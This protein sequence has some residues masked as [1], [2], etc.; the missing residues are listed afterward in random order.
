MEK[1]TVSFLW[2][3]LI[4]SLLTAV[5]MNVTAADSVAIDWSDPEVRRQAVIETAFAYYLK[6]DCIQ[7]DSVALVAGK[8]GLRITRKTIEKP[9]EY[10]TPDCIYHTVCSAFPYETYL[11]AIGYKIGGS[12]ARSITV[13]LALVPQEGV[14]VFSYDRR[15]DPGLKKQKSELERMRSLLEPGDVIVYVQIWKDKKTGRKREGGHA[16]IYLGDI[17][18]DGVAKIMHSAGN[19]YDFGRGVDRLESKG[20]IRF[21]DFDV[22]LFRNGK[23][24]NRTKIVVLRPLMLSAA[25]WP[26][27]VSAKAR[28]LH[29]RL[30]I[31]R[32]VGCGPYGSVVSG[33]VLEYSINLKNYSKRP[34][35]VAVHENLPN[36]TEFLPD[37][38][39]GGV[40]FKA[41]SEG[42]GASFAWD[43]RLEPGELRT[44]RWCVRV[45]APAGS[46]IVSAGGNVAGIISNTL[47][48]E[49]VPQ[50]MS[51]AAAHWWAAKNIHNINA[52]PDCRLEGWAGGRDTIEPP[53]GVRVTVPGSAQLMEGDVV[54]VCPEIAKPKDFNIWVKGRSGFEA[55]SKNGVRPVLEEEVTAILTN[56]FFA[57]L[58]P[59]R[60]ADS[61]KEWKEMRRRILDEAME[62]YR[63]GK[64]YASSFAYV[65]ETYRAA[66]GLSLCSGLSDCLVS[67]I[68]VSPPKGSVVF[69]WEKGVDKEGGRFRSEVD[70]MRATIE[71]GDVIAYM[72]EAAENQ[73]ESCHVMIYLGDVCDDGHPQI[74]YMDEGCIRRGGFHKMF[75]KG[76]KS[77]F[78]K[79][80]KVVVLRLMTKEPPKR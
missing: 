70:R 47:V 2:R 41:S 60:I 58:R 75:N 76:E 51:P 66:T 54:V 27:S 9:P 23:L 57:A 39:S 3:C 61:Q 38:S 55:N 12:P 25:E 22:H 42:K 44:I 19:K 71:P 73:S 34:Y 26:L 69:S 31:D 40:V 35:S 4:V 29:P 74:L 33:G 20:T 17:C 37:R 52:L 78:R 67:N 79:A 15:D 48:T 43:I 72:E 56:A 45:T 1:N 13:H 30:R 8:K 59:A 28:Y 68:V 11:N 21:D 49:V 46:R 80:T 63:S 18:G 64:V 53:R 7:Y 32:C 36:G 16:V 65:D 24:F 6:S 62:R 77:I 10:A 50:E 5:S 14:T